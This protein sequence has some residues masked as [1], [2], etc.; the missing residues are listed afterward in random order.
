[1]T[2]AML[3]EGPLLDEVLAEARLCFGADVEIEAANRV[4]RGGIL[5]FFASEWFEVWARP[6]AAVVANPA[7]R[8]AEED[9]ADTFQ[10]MVA[11]AMADRRM[12]G[13][14]PVLP[15]DDYD[16][17]LERFFDDDD[18]PG[19]APERQ[20]VPAG[21]AAAELVADLPLSSAAAPVG[22][23]PA[24]PTQPVTVEPAIPEAAPSP[25]PST[26]P[27]TTPAAVALEDAPRGDSVFTPQRA[28]KTELLWAMLDRLD[29]LPAAPALPTV[30]VVAFV[31]EAAAALDA[32]RRI[33]ERS[34]L[35]TGDV[36]V[37]T[38]KSEIE[39]VPSWLLIHD[40]DE[41]STM[42]ERWRQRGRV[43]PVIIDQGAEA[44]DRNWALTA[45]THLEADQ[46]RL[47][48]EAWRLPEDVGRLAGKLGGAD[49]I[50]LVSVTDT[51]EP[52]AMLD[53]AVPLGSIDARPASPE[54]MAAV[55]LENRRRA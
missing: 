9:D 13:D 2:N 24:A 23:T 32:V 8:L 26:I 35:W 52:L 48:V 28:P 1:M 34:G 44:G 47:V 15:E 40:L 33:G 31:G 54:L 37:V 38:R 6:S 21:A 20:L 30:G 22:E 49:A 3:F 4:R 50:E 17:A 19:A 39:G 16:T 14:G 5:G 11:N 7:L 46:V 41:L 53:L 51:V 25:I 43:V 27:L 29:A 10:S 55:W 45:V 12:T 36:A 18:G 42:A